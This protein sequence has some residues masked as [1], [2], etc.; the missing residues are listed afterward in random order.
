MDMERQERVSSSLTGKRLAL[1]VGVNGQPR[2]GQ[3]PLR[4]A[5]NDGQDMAQILQQPCCGFTLFCPPLLGEQATTSQVKAAVLDLAEIL[6]EDDFG[7][8]FFSGHA[9]AETL[10]VGTDLDEVYLVTHD[11]NPAH[12]KRDAHAHLS[13][14]WLRQIL[15]EHEKAK[16]ILFILD[17]CSAGKFADSASDPYL[18]TLQQRLYKY[19]GEP[20]AQSPARAGGIRLALTAT[21]KT[22]AK[23][24][25]GHGLLTGHILAAL[26]G[27]C[28][29]AIDELGHVTFNHLFS[30]LKKAMPDQPPRFFGAGDDLLLATH[31]HL[32]AQARRE[33]EQ[34]EQVVRNVQ[35][36][37]T[38]FVQTSGFWQDRL[39]SFVGREQELVE[40]QQ[41]IDELLPT[42]GY[43]TITG[44]AGVGKSSIIAKL[45]DIAAQKQGASEQVAYHFIP[46]TPP[47]DYQ[48]ALLRNLMARLIL[49]YHLSDL[50]LAS[51]S[52][53]AL[54]EG[55]PRVLQEIAEQ[56]GQEVIFIDG[57]D[58]LQ[59]DQ[60]TGWRDLSFLPQ[61][62]GNPPPG[63]VF[64]LGTRPDDTLRPLQL[65]K[66]FCEWKLPN[67]SHA[68]FECILQ[69]RGVTLARALTDRFYEI[70]DQ[71]ALYLDLVAKE[72]A[73]R[74]NMTQQEVEKIVQQIA[75]DPGN[76]FS[77]T[78]ERLSRQESLWHTV[79]KPVLG[80]LLVAEE[81]MGREA[82]KHVLNLTTPTRLDGEQLNRGLER[83][84]G[85]VVIDGQ[86][87]YSLFHLKLREYLRQ[88]VQRHQK[89][90]LFDREDEQGWHERFVAWCELHDLADI[91]QDTTNTSE[92]T[93]R[94]YA[95]EHYITH[96]YH[97]KAWDKLFAVL[98]EGAYGRAKVKYDPTTRAYALDLDLGR[99]AAAS[100]DWDQ[101]EAIQHLPHLW[102]YTLLRCSLASRA[103]RYSREAFELM[104]LLGHE[105]QA[106]GLAELLTDLDYR[107]EI[108]ILIADHLATQPRREREALQ[109][110]ARIWHVIGN[111]VDK[112]EKMNA[113]VELGKVLTDK[114]R[115]DEAELCWNE[116]ERIIAV[117]MAEYDYNEMDKY[118]VIYDKYTRIVEM[119]T[120]A[121]IDAQQW[122]KVEKV[123]AIT[124]DGW[125]K[126]QALAMLGTALADAQRW[127]EA[128]KVMV[129][130]SNKMFQAEMLVN[131][132][133]A[134]VQ[135]QRWEEAKQRWEEAEQ[136][137]THFSYGQQNTFVL[138]KLGK[139]LADV[140]LWEDAERVIAIITDER[141]KVQ[142][143]GELGAALARAQQWEKAKRYWE[144]AEQVAR[145]IPERLFEGE[146]LATLGTVLAQA[147]YLKQA[148]RYWK[149]AEQIAGIILDGTE[150]KFVLISLMEGLIKVQRWAEAERVIASISDEWIKADLLVRYGAM[151]IHA[152]QW[153]R[154]ER[155]VGM[156]S[157]ASG[158][159]YVL[160]ELGLSLIKAHQWEEAKQCW[161]RVEILNKIRDNKGDYRFRKLRELVIELA[162]KQMF[163]IS[164][165]IVEICFDGKDRL[166]ISEEVDIEENRVRKDGEIDLSIKVISDKWS[167]PSKWRALR[168]VL[169]RAQW[170][171]EARQVL[172]IFADNPC[173]TSIWSTL[174]VGLVQAQKWK[175]TAWYWEKVRRVVD[176][177]YNER[178]KASVLIGLATILVQAH[179][180]EGAT[181]C[182]EDIERVVDTI[183]DGWIKAD[184]LVELGAVLAQM[185]RWE[186][187]EQYWKK[188][189]KVV[190]LISMRQGQASLWI[191]LGKVR[192][193]A[194][195]WEEAQRCWNEAKQ[196]VG[197]LSSEM[198]KASAL[199]ELGMAL[200]S[201]HQWEEAERIISAIPDNCT[202][203]QTLIN[204][205]VML[206][207][208]QLLP[209]AEQCWQ[210]IEQIVDLISARG[211]MHTVGDMQEYS[212][213]K[214]ISRVFDQC[215]EYK[216]L[217]YLGQKELIQAR[218]ENDVLDRIF[219]TLPFIAQSPDLG[220]ALADA[221][222]WVDTFFQG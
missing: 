95:R 195:C 154:A 172:D 9:D 142:A 86:Q 67:L 174:V 218:S 200:A 104:L 94:L 135:I 101:T 22:T 220:L 66:P 79:I 145:T 196:V 206:S 165:K 41:K 17:C 160:V 14:S 133:L 24:R 8:F 71:N 141:S 15:F 222:T 11:F 1:V 63:I 72:L 103:D 136:I 221:F 177:A 48:V 138:M 183:Y 83:L 114:Q 88:D 50:F 70:L 117:D 30:Y 197:T 56:G 77:L 19:F 156:I 213:L 158:K 89:T 42:G 131:M 199:A 62:P 32:S 69:A 84:G 12:V 27:E 149:E 23:E 176:T 132:G 190:A 180:W 198:Y 34:A 10:S 214:D 201:A 109:L 5:V 3:A 111:I 215:K 192:L 169:T 189:E 105:T 96:L 18:A 75:D 49:K 130:I 217:M 204:L 148:E 65:L 182:W 37:R 47:P 175:L 73:Q 68:D 126:A 121:L 123:I 45:I 59:A 43:L 80:L 82:L 153:K 166:Y 119:L 161:E 29:Q 85:L 106:L 184:T 194:R 35:R 203:A 140:Y 146:A 87:R 112:W 54:S 25:D 187:A 36:L 124:P 143:L 33:R 181:Q 211:D 99:Q 53:A 127:E 191:K 128:E 144:E 46:L 150:K 115:W 51:E 216:R 102:R 118:S 152:Q 151:L 26:R 61:G 2:T 100:P 120:K 207:H 92:Q 171:E 202:K 208:A 21:G 167:K 110:F 219:L 179:G 31:P 60:Q 6:Q 97:A 113:L 55:F 129:S 76:L 7:L 168:I 210:E 205:S 162:K 178:S 125:N 91:W 159:V 16:H 209:K 90:Y 58:Q 155:V 134:L 164:K 188:A 93:R 57:L 108:F 64:V 139:V 74:E 44:Q 4:Y 20:S 13:L 98:D 81:P 52:R 137:I 116:A 212:K 40:V 157:E 28:E 193:E 107:A 186:E 185:Q 39:A 122:E 163:E 78:I 147:Q 38:M 170:L 173:K